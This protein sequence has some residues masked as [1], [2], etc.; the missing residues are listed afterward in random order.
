MLFFPVI[1]LLMIISIWIG[2]LKSF[3]RNSLKE[4]F[5]CVISLGF[6]IY[7]INYNKA[8]RYIEIENEKP[9]SA[10]EEWVSSIT[11]AV[12]AATI[13]HNYIFQPFI[14]PTGSLEKSL[15]IGDFLIVSKFHY[16]ARIPSTTIAFPMVHD[17]LPIV[18]TRSYLKKPQL[19]YLRIPKIQEIKKMILLFLIGLLIPLDNFLK[20]KKE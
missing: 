4:Y 10:L 3:G 16:G 14:I 13:V 6:Y 12:I 20:K 1:N 17:T 2:T 11:F 5:L 8:T 18:K 7:Y 9:K 19:P 15:L